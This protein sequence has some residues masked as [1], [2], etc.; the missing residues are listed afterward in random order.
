M[1]GSR[2][3]QQPAS[4]ADELSLPLLTGRCSC[5]VLAASSA[6]L[7]SCSCPVRSGEQGGEKMPPPPPTIRLGPPHPYLTTHGGK[8]ARLHLYDWVVLALLVAI[9][10]GLNLIEPFHRFVGEDMMAELRYP[11]K[12]NIVPVWAVPIYAVIGPIIIIVGIYMKQ[13]NVSDM[14]HAILGLLFSVL[15]TSVLTDAIKDGGGRPRP[16]FFWRCFPDGVTVSSVL[17]FFFRFAPGQLI[18]KRIRVSACCL[19]TE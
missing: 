13:R 18:D 19:E 12:S 16:N 2:R 10:V 4:R 14:H 17:I 1:S 7:D 11:L 6:R 9:D 15:V 3:L 5:H 8:V